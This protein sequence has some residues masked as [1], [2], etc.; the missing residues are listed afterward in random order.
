MAIHR[1]HR[2]FQAIG[3]HLLGL[4]PLFCRW[5]LRLPNAECN[6][7]LDLQLAC[8]GPMVMFSD[9]HHFAWL[10][11]HQNMDSTWI[12]HEFNH[13]NIWFF[14]PIWYLQVPWT[15][16]AMAIGRCGWRMAPARPS[17]RPLGAQWIRLSQVTKPSEMDVDGLRVT[18]GGC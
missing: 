10:I 16:R 18:S 5:W 11:N 17:D 7:F 6:R 13:E 2:F 9:S 4:Y 14:Y 8:F 3:I 1:W 12:L 15:A